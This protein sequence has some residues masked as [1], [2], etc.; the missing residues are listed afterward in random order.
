MRSRITPSSPEATT[1]AS[2]DRAYAS[3]EKS[4]SLTARSLATWSRPPGAGLQGVGRTVD[5]K[6]AMDG[7]LDARRQR[8]VLRFAVGSLAV[9]LLTGSASGP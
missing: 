2:H 8:L 1:V 6:E 3:V 5:T 4:S 9:F 7:D